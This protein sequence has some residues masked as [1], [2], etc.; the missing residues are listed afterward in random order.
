M[1]CIARPA[2]G[3]GTLHGGVHGGGRGGQ[4][5]YRGVQTQGRGA[6]QGHN[7]QIKVIVKLTSSVYAA[8]FLL[9][10]VHT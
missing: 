7:L 4:G 3:G 2:V 1:F 5:S 9:S 8:S 6:Y 10:G